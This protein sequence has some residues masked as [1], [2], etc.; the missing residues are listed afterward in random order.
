MSVRAAVFGWRW[1]LLYAASRTPRSHHVPSLTICHRLIIGANARVPELEKPKL[2]VQSLLPLASNDPLIPL[3]GWCPYNRGASPIRLPPWQPTFWH[4]KL[5]SHRLC[6][7]VFP[8]PPW[9]PS[10]LS[11]TTLYSS[12]PVT[13]HNDGVAKITPY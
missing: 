13:P 2:V 8:I 10:L 1:L 7:D 11:I 9:K 3:D 12:V 4:F 6:V 5:C